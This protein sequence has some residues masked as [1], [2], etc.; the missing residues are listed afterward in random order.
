MNFKAHMEIAWKLTL[1]N[2][3]PL[4]LMT[5]AF[6]VTCALSLGILTP[7]TMAGYMH[8]ILRMMRDGREPEVLDIF[9]HMYLFF[10]LLAFGILMAIVMAIGFALFLVPGIV[11]M[12][13]VTFC[14]LYM[15][16][17]MTDRGLGIIDAAQDSFRLATGGNMLEHLIV[18]IIF[19]V[20][21]WIGGF[22]VVGSLFTQPLATVFILSIYLERTSG[23]APS[24]DY[25]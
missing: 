24:P 6:M 15:Y 9:S 2:I 23:R 22:S 8:S 7:V 3:I 12:L 25:S 14:F 11:M 19:L 5:L 10:P 21:T 1:G 16:P 17:M 4:I 18:V 20:I 13:A